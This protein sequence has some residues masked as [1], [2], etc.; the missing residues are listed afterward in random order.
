MLA[1]AASVSA[2]RA[3]EHEEMRAALHELKIVQR[4][5]KAAPQTYEGHRMAALE[6]VARALVEVRQALALVKRAQA[7]DD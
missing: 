2:A 1:L 4:H 3:D 6:A 5:L 7:G